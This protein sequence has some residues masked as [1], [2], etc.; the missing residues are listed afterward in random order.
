MSLSKKIVFRIDSENDP[1][2]YSAF[3]FMS[4][5]ELSKLRQKI[6]SILLNRHINKRIEKSKR[7]SQ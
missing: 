7:I 5:R 6:D 1:L 4:S 3:N 2:Y